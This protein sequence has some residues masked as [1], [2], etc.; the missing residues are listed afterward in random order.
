MILRVLHELGVLHRQFIPQLI[1]FL[2]V[3]DSESIV[4]FGDLVDGGFILNNFCT[5]CK[6]KGGKGLVI[7]D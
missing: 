4:D 5:G 1:Y 7:V 6:P 3:L 2:L